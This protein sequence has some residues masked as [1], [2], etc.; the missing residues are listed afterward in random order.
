MCQRDDTISR[1]AA[2]DVIKKCRNESDMPDMWYDGMSCALRCIYQLPSA[3]SEITGEQA[4]EHLRE[5][6]WMQ[7][8]DKQMYEMGLREQLADDSDSYDALLTPAQ[9]YTDEEIQKIQELE[10][11]QFDKIRELAYQDG[12]ADAMAKI[13]R[14]R[15]CCYWIP[16]L[17]TD[18]DCFIPPKCG[19]YQ[20]GK[21]QQM[22]G[23]SA[24][25]YCS[26]AE[27]LEVSE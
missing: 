16:G 18:N 7:N 26:Y 25:D 12:K 22:V 2:I 15:D 3:Q 6:G 19:K 8:H 17:I 4:I 1:Q 14:C 13:I 9:P 21:Y 11:A 23:H 20:R 10:Q 27:R 5:S 24:D